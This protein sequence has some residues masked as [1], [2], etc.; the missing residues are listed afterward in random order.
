MDYPFMSKTTVERSHQRNSNCYLSKIDSGR[1]VALPKAQVHDE[2]QPEGTTPRTAM[3]L[4]ERVRGRK[5]HPLT[6]G[7]RVCCG[8]WLCKN[9]V[10]AKIR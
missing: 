7:A 4:V 10:K 6:A 9:A 2:M 3:W 8:S 5:L 1:H